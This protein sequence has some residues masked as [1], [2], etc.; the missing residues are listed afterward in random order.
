MQLQVLN[1]GFGMGLLNMESQFILL[2]GAT[3]HGIVTYAIERDLI[4]KR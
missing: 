1:Q 3:R 2:E 4:P